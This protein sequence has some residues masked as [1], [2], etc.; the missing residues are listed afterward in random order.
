[1]FHPLYSNMNQQL[2]KNNFCNQI[3]PYENYGQFLLQMEAIMSH[4]FNTFCG[5]QSRMGHKG[6]HMKNALYVHQCGKR[7]LLG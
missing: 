2:F 7:H 4:K 1:M 5:E 6:G 3:S